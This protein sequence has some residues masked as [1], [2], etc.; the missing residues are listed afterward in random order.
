MG[1]RVSAI[2]LICL[3]VAGFVAG[4]LYL[5]PPG[6]PA[7]PANLVQL[8]ADTSAVRSFGDYPACD[9]DSAVRTVVGI[10]RRLDTER[11]LGLTD[12]HQI[13][14][15]GGQHPYRDCGANVQRGVG[16]RAVRFRIVQ[17]PSGHNAWQITATTDPAA[18]LD[19]A[20]GQTVV[21]ERPESSKH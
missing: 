20:T 2:A 13:N 21:A 12:I 6:A 4:A 19:D 17:L 7:T 16:S 14:N 8:S 3:V 18:S 15:A 10:V 11:T 5:G 1:N 9:S